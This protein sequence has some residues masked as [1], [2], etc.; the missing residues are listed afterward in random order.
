MT[1]L[2]TRPLARPAAAQQPRAKNVVCA[3]HKSDMWASI[4]GV[5]AAA[6]LSAALLVA[7][8]ANAEL[9]KYEAEG[10]VFLCW[11]LRILQVC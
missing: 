2:A 1:P 5:G 11:L 3:A 4:K 9:N 10:I 8:P 6:A 7:Q